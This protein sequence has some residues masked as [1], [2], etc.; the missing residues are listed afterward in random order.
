MSTWRQHL[1]FS[2]SNERDIGRI[3]FSRSGSTGEVQIPEGWA[4]IYAD[5]MEPQWIDL[6]GVQPT[7]GPWRIDWGTDGKLELRW[8]GGDD[9]S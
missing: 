4:C 3:S 2:R 6:S 8:V 7:D 9:D 5:G 1:R